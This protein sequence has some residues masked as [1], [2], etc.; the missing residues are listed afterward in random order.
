MLHFEKMGGSSSWP[1]ADGR[2][3]GLCTDT[4]K[5]R[6]QPPTASNVDDNVNVGLELPEEW[7]Y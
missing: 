1:H 5:I 2:N 7:I 6:H 3:I 4:K